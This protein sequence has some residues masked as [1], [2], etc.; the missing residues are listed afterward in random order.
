M[1][2]L[3]QGFLV[4]VSIFIKEKNTFMNEEIKN[5]ANY[6]LNCKL[7]PCTNKGCPL[8]ND[9]PLFISKI[10]EQKYEDP[11]RLCTVSW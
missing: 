8:G 1:Y 2:F 10:K 11:S 3:Y 7:K 5:K 4:H 9:I 6:C